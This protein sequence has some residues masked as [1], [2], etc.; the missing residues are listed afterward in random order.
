MNI[1]IG[2]ATFTATLDD[3]PTAR[4]FRAMLPITVKMT[5]LNGNEK[6]FDLPTS[7]PTRA[8]NP[9]TIQSGDLMLYGSRTLV[10]FYRTFPT[11]YSYTRLGRIDHPEK[12]AAAVGS[13]NVTVTF[14]PRE[15]SHRGGVSGQPSEGGDASPRFDRAARRGG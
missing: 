5:E 13:G 11:S 7:L 14:G 6:F 10:L 9:G 3:S 2:P 4:A 1:K 8:S 12:L 15:G